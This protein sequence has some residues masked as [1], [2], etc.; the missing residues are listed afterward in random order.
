MKRNNSDS[1]EY[2]SE[3]EIKKK[4]TKKP[5]INKEKNLILKNIKKIHDTQGNLEDRILLS[6]FDIKTK[7]KLYKDYQCSTADSNKFKTYIDTVLKIPI[8][9]HVEIK[10]NDPGTFLC[11]L[12]KNLD[13]SIYGHYETKE[14]ILD[15]MASKIN[16]PDNN[17]STILALQS[18]PGFGKC[19][20]RDTPVLMYDSSIKLVQDIY[21]GDVIMGDDS[22]PRNV[23]T[24]GYGA[25]MLYKI[26][27]KESL[28][29]YTVNDEHI[30]SLVDF[31]GNIVDMTI[32][33]YINNNCNLKGF[34]TAIEYPETVVNTQFIIDGRISNS[35]Y[36]NSTRVRIKFLSEFMSVYGRV[37]NGDYTVSFIGHNKLLSDLYFYISSLGFIVCRT[38]NTL[39]IKNNIDMILNPNLYSTFISAE[40]III[41][42]GG[43]GQYYGFTIDSNCRFVLAN[44]IVTHNTRFIRA[45]GK[46]LG[47]PLGQIS[48][49]GMNDP[50]ILVGHDYTYIGSRPGKIYDIL[51]KSECMN[52]I[53]YLDECFP[54]WQ[55]IKT[56]IG[57]IPI[58]QLY[59][60]FINNKFVPCVKSFNIE[61][62]VFEFKKITNVWKKP[63]Q[64]LM[65]ITFLFYNKNKPNIIKKITVDCT[66]NHPFLTVLGYVP[67][68]SLN[69]LDDIISETNDTVIKF[70]KS[71]YIQNK[72]G[73]VYD[74]EVK[75]NH[76]FVIKDLENLDNPGIIVHNCDKI[77]E[78]GSQRTLE[79]NG[80][81]THIL[82]KE[83]NMDFHDHYIGNIPLDLSKVMFILSFNNIHNIDPVVLNRLKVIKIKESTLLEKIEIVKKFTIPD[84][85][86]ILGVS[87]IEIADEVIKYIITT[88]SNSEVDKGMRTINRNIH[89]I[90][91]KLNTILC[92]KNISEEDKKTIVKD[93]I[94]EKIEIPTEGAIIITTSIVDKLLVVSTPKHL[95]MY[96]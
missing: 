35:V 76:N 16:N 84:I 59:D 66:E 85:S 11:T 89:T 27:H 73:H 25:S 82:D 71:M 29:T 61:S 91:G 56:S 57:S 60:D 63:N 37:S 1:D 12:R 72:E 34:T 49:G 39:I 93:L 65:N 41:E 96:M 44:N 74:I 80:L 40:D 24:L 51:A 13:E 53:I 2:F 78:L 69:V 28:K 18:E 86:K 55:H 33:D 7:A 62:S 10:I 87:N 94:Y 31:D 90:Y 75:D 19:L 4:S 5:K 6:S 79:I 26:T 30:L 67:A 43:Y 3:S 70:S 54:S 48:F 58:K 21:V 83:Q 42:S 47:L 14:E 68:K 8:N 81:L 92:L 88:K 64:K 95:S 22:T 46:S 20:A 9:K 38:S 50:A 45:L 17:N 36:Y 15:Y 77:G 23:I 32:K 52:P